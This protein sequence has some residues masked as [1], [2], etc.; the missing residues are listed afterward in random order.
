MTIDDA[1]AYGRSQLT[2]SPTPAL[3]ARLLL[4]HLL[5]VEHPY[6]IAHGD[7][8]LTAVQA[9]AYRT[10]IDRARR[11]EPIPYITGRAPFFDM[12]LHVTPAVLIPRPETELLVERAAD[13]AQQ[14]AIRRLVDVGTGSGCI[15]IA[16]AR[17]LPQTAVIALDTSADAL[18]VARRNAAQY[19]PQR[20]TFYQGHLLEPVPAPIDLIIANLPYVTDHEWTMLD[21]AVKLHEPSTALKGG[22]D[23]LDLVRELLQQASSKLSAAGAIFLE[24]GWQQG[25]AA[26][27]A[28]AAAF[29]QAR[30]D[31][32]PDHAGHDRLVIIERR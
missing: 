32:A 23:G 25:A 3:D 11:Q 2:H 27:A 10:L 24:I 6:L 14:R 15:A 8:R 29:P 30:I 9:A 21:D 4:Q 22:A 13:W 19:A 16:L 5:G 7:A 31:V 12:A 1:L 20:I 28:A 26:R 18:T 17:R